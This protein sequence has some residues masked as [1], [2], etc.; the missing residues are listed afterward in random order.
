MG[1]LIMSES[2]RKL[3]KHHFF[4]MIS[5]EMVIQANVNVLILSYAQKCAIYI[6]TAHA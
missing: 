4:I 1:M 5:K 2:L 6:E 3:S